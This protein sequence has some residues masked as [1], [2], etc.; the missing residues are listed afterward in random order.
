MSSLF[1]ETCGNYMSSL[2][3]HQCPPRWVC[4]QVEDTENDARAIYAPDAEYA[5]AKYAEKCDQDGDYAYAHDGGSNVL[6]R[7]YGTK[8]APLCFEISTGQTINYYAA[9]TH[10]P[11]DLK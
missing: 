4:W 2:C 7:P 6:V 9:E 8:D 1:C 5:A 3:K 10:A 11:E